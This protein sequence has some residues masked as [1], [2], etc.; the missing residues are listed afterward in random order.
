MAVLFGSHRAHMVLT[1]QCGTAEGLDI[2]E[3]DVE[4]LK[5]VVYLLYFSKK[6]LQIQLGHE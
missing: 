5:G 1:R 6:K 3:H 2:E 4:I